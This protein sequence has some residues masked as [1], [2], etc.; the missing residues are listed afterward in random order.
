MAAFFK[1]GD[2]LER[3][4]RAARPQASDELVSRIEGR[5][6]QERPA[7]RQSSL[8]FAVPAVLTVAMI[9]ALAAV[10]GVSYAAS[11]VVGAVHHVTKVFSPAKAHGTLTIAGKTSG[12][13]QYQPGFQFGSSEANHD[14]APALSSGGT[15]S[16]SDKGAFAPPLQAN[17]KGKTAIVSTKFTVDEQAH[18]F[19]SVINRKTGKPILITQTKSKIGGNL[20]GQQA[21]NVNYLVLVPRTIPLKLAIPANLLKSGQQYAIRIVARDPQKNKTKLLIPFSS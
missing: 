13:D 15:T 12:G 21:K 9:S 5:I 10:G 2:S 4:L 11:G 14:G 20:E 16:D 7:V 8:R 17:V 3:E 1:R 6:A 19:I 18:L